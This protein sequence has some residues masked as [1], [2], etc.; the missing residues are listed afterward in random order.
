MSLNG[1]LDFVAI[2]KRIIQH[3]IEVRIIKRFQ[4]PFDVQPDFLI[5]NGIH[6]PYESY[7]HFG[8]TLPFTFNI[9]NALNP[10]DKARLSSLTHFA[11][12][13]RV[14]LGVFV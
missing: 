10:F 6:P 14:V 2:R 13:R 1:I 7:K 5:R 8:T 11:K 9:P 12:G 3:L 4:D